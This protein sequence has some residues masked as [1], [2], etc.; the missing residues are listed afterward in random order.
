MVGV[1][2]VSIEDSFKVIIF[3][4]VRKP[5]VP[6]SCVGSAIAF[7]LAPA[8]ISLFNFVLPGDPA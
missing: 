7:A 2:V 1:W 8:P 5:E 3:S 6:V 4:Q